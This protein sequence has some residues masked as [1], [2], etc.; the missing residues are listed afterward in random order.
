MQHHSHD[1]AAD[2]KASTRALWLALSINAAFLLIEFIGGLL[3]GSL[4]L[5]ADAGH[6]LTDVAAL[7]IALLA[8]K[9]AE[10]PA[11][12][13]RS[14]GYGRVKVLSAL[15]N[16]LSLW[17]IVGLIIWEAIHRLAQPPQIKSREML[18]I[19]VAGLI[20]N[21]SS[22]WVLK[23]FQKHDLNIR[24]AFLH[25][26]ADSLGSVAVILA[27][28]VILWK[29][30]FIAD[31]IASLCISMVILW[32]SLGIIREAL[33]I[34]LESTPSRI[35][36][37]EVKAYLESFEEVQYCHDIHIWSI[38]SDQPILT[39][40]LVVAADVSHDDLLKR[41]TCAVVEKFGISHTTLQ[42]ES[43]HQHPDLGCNHTLPE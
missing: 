2:I 36:L 38:G 6:M 41:A 24:G 15:L 12:T 39:A 20:A 35:N 1:Q 8:S 7:F 40:H 37:Q 42:L 18:L 33:R 34:L 28:V 31:P 16:G 25:L 4:A 30:W 27:G 10:Y 29:G 9:I 19:A 5:L 22:A 13:K 14:Y 23:R 3:T 17:L 11:S 21:V 43:S 26:I 32:S